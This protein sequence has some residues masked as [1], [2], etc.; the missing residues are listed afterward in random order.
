MNEKDSN[1][2]LAGLF[3]ANKVATFSCV[4]AKTEALK[5]CNFETPHKP[6][7]DWW[8]WCQIFMAGKVV[9]LEKK[10]TY[11]RKHEDSYIQTSNIDYTFSGKLARFNF[12]NQKILNFLHTLINKKRIEKMFRPQVRKLND[13]LLYKM[14]KNSDTKLEFYA[15]KA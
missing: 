7:L 13:I 10:L 1:K 2:I 6:Y 15:I 8:L 5:K 4:M 9:F 3:F 12:K 11:W 14:V